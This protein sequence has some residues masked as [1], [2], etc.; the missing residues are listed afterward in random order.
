[1]AAAHH[2]VDGLTAIVDFNKVSQSGRVEH[3]VGVEPLV[4]K[5]RAFG[6]AVREIDGHAMA[7]V[8]DAL[9][10]VPF[11]AG[12]PSVV[13]AH[14]VKGK[15]VSFAEDTHVWHHNAVDDA[16]LAR[17]LDELPPR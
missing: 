7:E 1:M 17:A 9:D 14:T 4:D 15:G 8:V 16:T 11:A 13:V 3:L 5:W 6:W 2:R 10:A 12:R